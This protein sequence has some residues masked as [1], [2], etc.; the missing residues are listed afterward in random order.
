[1][2]EQTCAPTYTHS[3]TMDHHTT[4]TTDDYTSPPFVS[5]SS[6]L[7][8][9]ITHQERGMWG[10]TDGY[11]DYSEDLVVD[12][13][14]DPG[15]LQD[16]GVTKEFRETLQRP[17]LADCTAVDACVVLGYFEVDTAL[18]DENFPPSPLP[19]VLVRFWTKQDDREKLTI[20]V[21]QF[22]DWM[23]WSEFPV[24]KFPKTAL[25]ILAQPEEFDENFVIGG[26]QV[27]K[28][29]GR[30]AKMAFPPP[31]LT[32]MSTPGNRWT[33]GSILPA[34]RQGAIE[35][36]AQLRKILR[37]SKGIKEEPQK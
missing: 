13:G 21:K 36:G 26:K 9:T 20:C 1:M 24:E 34:P 12:G 6:T 28:L 19:A 8:F 5:S 7:S 31:P 15:T 37:I 30:F 10:D 3:M 22:K 32:D 33:S 2:P 17:A 35:T 29:Q 14:Q 23:E 4:V 25:L 16:L 27:K 11:S 18:L